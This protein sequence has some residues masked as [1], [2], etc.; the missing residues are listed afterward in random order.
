[1]NGVNEG[2]LAT[3]SVRVWFGGI[4]RLAVAHE[5][6]MIIGPVFAWAQPLGGPGLIVCNVAPAGLLTSI[7]IVPPGAIAVVV[8]KVQ[9]TVL[10]VVVGTQ[11]ATQA[12]EPPGVTVEHPARP[13][14]ACPGAPLSNARQTMI[15]AMAP[16]RV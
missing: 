10:A 8:V 4:P 6:V 13:L 14:W 9:L 1:M 15:A 7:S 11:L 2:T 5:I 12:G 16:A 3:A